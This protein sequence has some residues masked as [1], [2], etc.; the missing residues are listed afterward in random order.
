MPLHD[1]ECSLCGETFEEIVDWN[2]RTVACPVCGG[3]SFRIYKKFN[4]IANT[5]P[6]WLK[7]TLAVVDKD[8]GSHCKEFLKHPNRDN[9]KNWLKKEGLRPIDHG[10]R[11]I[12]R[13]ADTSAI[14]KKVKENF[15]S[16]NAITVRG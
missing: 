7:D 12:K 1:Y 8:G 15:A 6:D 2:I 13:E 5:A 3:T 10:E 16:K 9:Y 11:L 14:R 4:G